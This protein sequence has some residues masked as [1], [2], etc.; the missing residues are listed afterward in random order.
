MAWDLL[1]GRRLILASSSP[2]RAWILR[3]VGI[4]FRTVAVEVEENA[5]EGIT[6]GDYVLTLAERKARSAASK[7]RE[8]VVLGADTIV[9]FQ[10]EI[11][12]KP[13]DAQEAVEMLTRLSGNI[14]EVYT[15]LAIID[16]GRGRI[17]TGYEV[18][19]VKFRPLSAEFIV[20]YVK[21]GEPLD[22]AGAYG[23]QKKGALLVE[24]VKGCFYNVVGLPLAR[25]LGLLRELGYGV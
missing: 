9:F 13:R 24:W 20:N 6:P 14:H 10:G 11:M 19:K 12:G 17:A 7:L 2:R 1:S 4:R 22:K 23:V 8:G 18:T 25:L 21:T 5:E 3:Q 16:V 15:G